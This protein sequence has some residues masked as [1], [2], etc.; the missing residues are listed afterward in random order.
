MS[1][2]ALLLVGL[3]LLLVGLV[4]FPDSSNLDGLDGLD[5]R[6]RVIRGY[7]ANICSLLG[8]GLVLAASVL[9][10]VKR[11]QQPTPPPPPA[12]DHNS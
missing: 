11:M 9:S 12:V 8:V 7:V 1:T 6:S 4:V 5:G 3:A 10:A 2:R